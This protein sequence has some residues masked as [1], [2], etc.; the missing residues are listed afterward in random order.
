MWGY[1]KNVL[2][3]FDQLLNT[4]FK[5]WPDESLSARAYRLEQERGRKWARVL[6]DAVLFFDREHCYNSYLSEIER[7]QVPPSMRG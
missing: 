4:I 3:A 2:V 5:G 6:I 7:R 1:L